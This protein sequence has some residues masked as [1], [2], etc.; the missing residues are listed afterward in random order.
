MLSRWAAAG[1]HGSSKPID[2]R[3]SLL[4]EARMKLEPSGERMIL[5]HY[6]SSPHDYVIYLLHLATYR[7]AEQFA[8]GKRVLDYGCGSGYGSAQIAAVASQVEAVDVSDDAISY[9]RVHYSA[10]NL[11]F[12]PINPETA[13]PF[14]DAFFDT[15]LS[16]QV[17]EH[18]HDTNRYLSEIRRVLAPGGT[19]VLVTPDR[20]TRLLPLQKPWNRWHVHEYNQAD[21]YKRLTTHF[22]NVSILGMGGRPDFINIEI[23]RCRKVK[24]LSLPFTLPVIPDA[25]RIAGLNAIH[26]L[27]GT[28]ANRGE[29]RD[30]PFNID[31]VTIGAGIKPSVNLVAV[32]S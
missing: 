6:K 16:F 29:P 17:F 14:D 32:A 9:A 31:D 22:S 3:Q 5:E 20:S 11:R 8:K 21:L 13:L 12:S 27:R 15:V 19:L 7:F 26:R 30:Y 18:V 24:W 10:D 2:T 1:P 25:W 28:G 4:K 23:N